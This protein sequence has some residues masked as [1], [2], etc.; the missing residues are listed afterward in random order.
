MY[1]VLPI[2]SDRAAE[3][4]PITLLFNDLQAWPQQQIRIAMDWNSALRRWVIRAEHDTMGKLFPP[5]PAQIA[6]IYGFRDMLYLIF[7]DRTGRQTRVS[8]QNLGDAVQLVAVPGM[9]NPV[10][11]TYGE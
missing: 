5:S 11:E 3:K 1:E 9:E 4:R 2:P 8:P 10:F 7:R 6:R